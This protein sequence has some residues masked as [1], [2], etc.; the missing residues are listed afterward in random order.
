[1]E[2][3]ILHLEPLPEGQKVDRVHAVLVTD[4]E[5]V[6]LR[7]KDHRVR[8]VTGGHIDP[9]DADTKA[10]LERELLEEINCK[11]D[12]CDYIGYLEYINEEEDA[13]EIWARMVARVSEI[14]L[15]KPDPDRDDEWTYGRMLAT[16][17]FARE[18]PVLPENFVRPMAELLEKALEIAKENNYFTK[19]ANKQNEVINEEVHIVK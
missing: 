11:I 12:K 18:E 4:D 17:E 6:F 7:Y 3:F 13:H 2:K 5:R 16:P 1:M 19:S 9:G 10:A 8:K 14:G 15:A